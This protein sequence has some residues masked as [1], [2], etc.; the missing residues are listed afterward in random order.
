MTASSA[1]AENQFRLSATVAAGG[2]DPGRV[3]HRRIAAR[4][5]A[6]LGQPGSTPP[7]YTLLSQ[8]GPE[9]RP[10]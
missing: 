1:P 9:L 3:L 7:G 6:K 2:A 10:R 8:R 5:G 4:D